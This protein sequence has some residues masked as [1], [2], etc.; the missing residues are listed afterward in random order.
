MSIGNKLNVGDKTKKVIYEE[1]NI[2]ILEIDDTNESI[3]LL[4]PMYSES[5]SREYDNLTILLKFKDALLV[6]NILNHYTTFLMLIVEEKKTEQRE[7]KW[8]Y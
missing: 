5:L 1:T 8:I 4:T 6:M 2:L 7:K 3:K